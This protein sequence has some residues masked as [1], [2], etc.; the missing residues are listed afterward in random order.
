LRVLMPSPVLELD[1]TDGG[2]ADAGLV[3]DASGLAL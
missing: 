2:P 1:E 3:D